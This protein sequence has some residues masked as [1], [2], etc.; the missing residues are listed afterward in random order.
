MLIAEKT[1]AR[2][3]GLPFT[4]KP[5]KDITFW[6]VFATT[7]RQIAILNRHANKEIRKIDEYC[8]KNSR[9]KKSSG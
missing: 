8:R 4:Y 7:T 3:A 5:A 1:T 6:I 2:G 9:D